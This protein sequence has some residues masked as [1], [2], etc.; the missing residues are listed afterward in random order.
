MDHRLEKLNGLIG[1]VA[2]LQHAAALIEWD[3][4]VC[5]PAGGAPVHGEMLATIRR[6]AHEKF[7]ADEVGQLLDDLTGRQADLDPDSDV[8]RTLAV[9]ARDYDKATRVPADFVAEQA[10]ITS[11]AQQAWVEARSQSS[12]ALFRPHLEKIVD[13]KQRYVGFFPNAEHPYDHLLDDFEPGMKTTEVKAIF[14]VLRPRQVDLIRAISGRPQIDDSFLRGGYAE[15]DM[16]DFSKEVVTALGF[17]WARGRQDKSVHPFA[18]SVG[19]DDVRITTR[20]VESLPFGLLFGIIHETGHALYE[21]GIS[22]SYS[23]TLLEGATSLG[24]HESQSRLWEKLVGQSLPFWQ[25]FFPSLQ[26]RFPAQLGAVTVERFYGAINKVQP[27]LIR[28]EADEATYNLHIMLRVELEI[29]MLD[30]NVPVRDLP[31]LWNAKMQEYLGLTPNDD[32]QGVLQDIHWSAGIQGYF[33]TYA[34]GNLISCQL[35]ETFR[36]AHPSRDD[37]MRRGDFSALLSW[38]RREI[39]QSGRKYQPQ[40]LVQRVVGSKIDPEPYLRYLERKY[41]GIYGL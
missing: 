9:T 28:V 35:W 13:L 23:R 12:F 32:A 27:S 4:R 37:D 3:E 5:M 2:D 6:I 24:V 33:A 8:S 22:R 31:G 1:E 30:G 29:A 21:Q 41:G 38:L 34:L 40:E 11:A 20:F 10:Q 18:T 16:W 17:D 36:S 26:K 39:H 7:T 19:P 14:D 25:H 15:K